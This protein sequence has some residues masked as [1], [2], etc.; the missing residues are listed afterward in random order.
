MTIHRTDPLAT[1]DSE[2]TGSALIVQTPDTRPLFEYSSGVLSRFRRP[3]TS[4][5][6]QPGREV[7]P[8]MRPMLVDST[9]KSNS[10][11]RISK[12]R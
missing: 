11:L 10:E 12:R 7:L 2:D 1:L 4:Y 9:R 8:T 3:R 6:L 5:R